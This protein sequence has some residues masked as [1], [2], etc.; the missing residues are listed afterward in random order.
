[1]DF[2]PAQERLLEAWA[3]MLAEATKKPAAKKAEKRA[4]RPAL[5]FTPEEFFEA[6]CDTG[7]VAC[8]P[9]DKNWFGRLGTKLHNLMPQL[10]REDMTALCEWLEDGGVSWM[11]EP[12]SFGM[13]ID[14]LPDWLAR[15]RARE[16]V[17][18][19]SA[20]DAFGLEVGNG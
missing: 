20:E 13:L 8:L 17:T 9:Y 14:K 3:K 5:P 12:P 4:S 2:T 7:K 18:G 10:R 1:M 16:T 11:S 15:A 19:P 6:V